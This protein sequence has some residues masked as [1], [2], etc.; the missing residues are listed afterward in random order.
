MIGL[1]I[2]VVVLVGPILVVLV[3]LVGPILV[4]LVGPIV[5]ALDLVVVPNLGF[6]YCVRVRGLDLDFPNLTFLFNVKRL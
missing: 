1:T 5:L 6:P 4:V 3:V 2:L